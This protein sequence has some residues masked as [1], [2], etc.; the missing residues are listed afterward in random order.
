[1]KVVVIGSP[2]A[3]WGFALTGV[4]GQVAETASEL[5]AALDDV[6][7]QRDVGVVLITEDVAK[8]AQDRIADLMARSELPLFVQIPGPEGPDPDRPSIG[9]ILRRTLGVRL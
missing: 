1:M 8:L 9:E 7:E 6:L 4:H 3:V 5:R 2:P